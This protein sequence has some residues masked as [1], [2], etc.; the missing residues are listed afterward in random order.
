MRVP[1]LRASR[2]AVLLN[3]VVTPGASRTKLLDPDP[4]RPALRIAVAAPADRGKA[5]D[6][7]LRFLARAL[8]VPRSAVAIARGATSRSKTVAIAGLPEDAVRARLLRG[9]A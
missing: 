1:A 8:G 5:N 6:E 2:G 3:V 9:G 4:W 7:L